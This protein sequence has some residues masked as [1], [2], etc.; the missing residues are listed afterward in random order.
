[1]QC[2]TYYFSKLKKKKESRESVIYT[3]KLDNMVIKDQNP[4]EKKILDCN[5][6]LEGFGNAKTV[7]NDNSSR[8]G[9]YVKIKI[10]KQSNLIEGAQMY[11]YL[12]EKIKLNFNAIK[13]SYIF[14]KGIFKIDIIK[15]F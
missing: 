15:I 7:R 14:I 11:T 3:G 1:M 13:I 2:I 9:K 4:L 10:N 8:F 12:L 6:I 5:P